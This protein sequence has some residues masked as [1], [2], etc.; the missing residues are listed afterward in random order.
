MTKNVILLTIDELRSD[1]LG[2]YG[3]TKV[4]T[5]NAD[6][7]AKDGV[8]F[9][10]AIATADLTPVCHGSLLTGTFPNKN[11]IRSPF[12]Y[13]RGKTM[14]EIFKDEGY[15]N[16][17]FVGVSFL[18]SKHGFERGFDY[19]E[20]AL[21]GKRGAENFECL[22]GEKG[23]FTLGNW[24][25]DDFFSWLDEHHE[26]PFF[27]WG[28]Y[29]FV[30][31]GT[32][33]FLLEQ[34][35]LD[36]N[37]EKDFFYLNPKIDIMDK[38][39]LGPLFKRL[40]DWGLY[41]DCTI[42]LMSDHGANLGEHPVAKSPMGDF[43]Y[44]QHVCLYDEDIH[45]PLIIKSPKLPAGKTIPG[46]VRQVDV[47]PT[48][49]DL[50][51]IEAGEAG[52]DFDGISLLPFIE[53]GKAEGLVNYFEDLY[54]ARGPG[55]LQG[56]RTDQFKFWRNLSAWTEELYDLIKDPGE[57]VNLIEERLKTDPTFVKS[58]RSYLNQKLLPLI[59]KGSSGEGYSL[60]TDDQDII[61]ARLRSLGYIE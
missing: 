14:A 10:E 8:L 31:Q 32:E 55:A 42:I 5:P 47:L 30:H 57:K 17:G 49:L 41:D 19:Y 22:G 1:G 54:E 25:L 24:W 48:V 2:C 38:V 20:E 27:L 59:P 56:M 9:T 43:Y 58:C 12:S 3:N 39:L 6:S 15:Y 33:D 53:A 46:M 21:E 28:H 35:I 40:K 18:G 51:G 29:F 50:L 60:T 34:G 36:P 44:P 26:K 45:I 16:G 23:G 13:L 7:L 4:H 37:A 61:E 52:G 11:C